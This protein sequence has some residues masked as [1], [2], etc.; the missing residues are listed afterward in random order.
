MSEIQKHTAHVT[1]G[2]ENLKDCGYIFFDYI[3]NLFFVRKDFFKHPIPLQS[4]GCQKAGFARL[5]LFCIKTQ[6]YNE[7]VMKHI[8]FLFA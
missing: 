4:L 6:V 8:I 3:E 1:Q 2:C 7:V 5:I